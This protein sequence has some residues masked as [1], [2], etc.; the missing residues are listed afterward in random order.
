LRALASRIIRFTKLQREW[1]MAEPGM[2]HW[3]TKQLRPI[4]SDEPWRNLAL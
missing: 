4:N 1:V 3:S 2:E